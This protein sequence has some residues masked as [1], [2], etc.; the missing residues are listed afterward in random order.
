MNNS[1]NLYRDIAISILVVCGV[2]GFMSGEFIISTALFGV[3]SLLSNL[4]F[5]SESL[6]S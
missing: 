1:N 3:S 4:N 2:L 6:H 5:E